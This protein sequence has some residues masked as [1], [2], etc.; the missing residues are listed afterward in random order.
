MTLSP[1]TGLPAPSVTVAMIAGLF[2][3]PANASLGCCVK[4]M[5]AAAPATMLN[6]LPVVES[7]PSVAFSV[8]VPTLFID[9]L[10]NVALPLASV[11]CGLVAVNVDPAKPL[12]IAS[13]TLPPATALPALS[14]TCATSVIGEPAAMFAFVAGCVVKL[15]FAAAPATMANAP[16]SPGVR[17]A[18]VA[19]KV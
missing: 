16:L 15:M 3:M 8:P 2:G 13:A 11:V 12:A 6:E 17:L 14:V 9:T 18:S 7:A 4:V 5:F 19:C 1:A 10:L